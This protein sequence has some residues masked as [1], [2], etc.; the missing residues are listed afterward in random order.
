[1]TDDLHP[2][3]VRYGRVYLAAPTEALSRFLSRSERPI[4]AAVDALARLPYAR[5][6]EQQGTQHAIVLL[7]MTEERA[8]V[9]AE[10]GVECGM[11]PPYEPSVALIV[12]VLP[13]EAARRI[14]ENSTDASIEQFDG[15]ASRARLMRGYMLVVYSDDA[16]CF[17]HAIPSNVEVA[18]A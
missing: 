11:L 4:L 12:I 5:D 8:R 10:V 13:V 15:A 3:P 17:G 2:R 7:D 6:A 9:I 18:R 14:V 16:V 1:M